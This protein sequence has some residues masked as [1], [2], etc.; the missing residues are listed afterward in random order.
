MSGSDY[1]G[2]LLEEGAADQT[3]EAPQ[4]S[5][6]LPTASHGSR[7]GRAV[8]FAYVAVTGDVL[9]L[10]LWEEWRS[11]YVGGPETRPQVCV[12]VCAS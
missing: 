12:C 2:Q 5:A 6:R 7:S 3:R 8:S 11:N 1:R 10:S 4:G 9:G